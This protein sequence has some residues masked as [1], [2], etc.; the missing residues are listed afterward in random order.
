MLA[1]FPTLVA[2]LVLIS[3]NVATAQGLSDQQLCLLNC[4][5]AAVTASACGGDDTACQCVSTTYVTN[6]TQCATGCKVSANDI[7]SFLNTS[8]PAGFAAVP[9]SKDNSAGFNAVRVGAAA[10]SA[11]GLIFYALLV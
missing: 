6:I 5:T 10:A 7:K 1:F 8:C 9:G 2:G 11:A 4:S 3:A